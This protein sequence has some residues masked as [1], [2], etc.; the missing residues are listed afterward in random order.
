MGR[1][2]PDEGCHAI[3]IDLGTT[4]ACVAVAKGREIAVVPDEHDQ[5]VLSAAVAFARDGEV[6]VGAAARRAAL[7]DPACAVIGVKRLL[8]RTFDAAAVQAARR[9]MPAEVTRTRQGQPALRLGGREVAP[10]EVAA[11]LLRWLR[12]LAR[13]QLGAPVTHAVLAAPH[14]FGASQRRALKEAAALAGFAGAAIVS[15]PAA[16]ALAY[17]V[18]Q[19][20]DLRRLAIVSVGGGGFDATVVRI[21]DGVFE[22]L[23]TAGDPALGGDDLVLA[24]VDAVIDETRRGGT[25]IPSD[26]RVVVRVRDAVENALGVL[27]TAPSA[28]IDVPVGAQRLQLELSRAALEASARPLLERVDAACREALR[29]AGL[30]SEQIDHVV[31]V[32]AT[33]R[34]PI[35]EA[36]VRAT[37]NRPVARFN[38]GEVVA[39]GAATQA[40]IASGTLDQIILLDILGPALSMRVRGGDPAP[41]LP[42][43]TKLP[44]R[45][46]KVVATTRDQED[47][48]EVEMVQGDAEPTRLVVT[49]VP[50][51]PA[52]AS[53]VLL[54]VTI[55]ANGL[56]HLE[57]TDSRSGRGLPVDS[58]PA[59]GRSGGWRVVDTVT[60][61][62]GPAG[63]GGEA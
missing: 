11:H 8:G 13:K 60:P 18:H 50:R 29:L 47:T 46:R 59:T 19:R 2:G 28:L 37:F 14:A 23:A 49:S 44:A 6:L 45:A 48:I 26:R 53:R 63:P 12:G 57:A 55:D 41:L 42:T 25:A 5:R 27:A 1:F 38:T 32:G 62:S 3:G 31:L 33:T 21:S 52:G 36:R 58:A 4:N 16:A 7:E 17:G 30:R 51:A 56:L 61:R 39:A 34:M 22:V 20:T 24:V 35:V 15:E 40:A 54:D 10:V 43:G 9:L